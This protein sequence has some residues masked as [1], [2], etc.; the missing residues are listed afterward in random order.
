MRKIIPLLLMLLLI[1]SAV[2]MAETPAALSDAE[3]RA[4]QTAGQGYYVEGLT[5]R[6]FDALEETTIIKD[7]GSV[8]GYTVT[9]RYKDPD[10]PACASAASGRSPMPMVSPW[11]A[12][13]IMSRKSGRLATLP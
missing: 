7:P 8:T 12:S 1:C 5:R 13:P 3:W 6:E 9:F 11:T 2:A 10:A 4:Q